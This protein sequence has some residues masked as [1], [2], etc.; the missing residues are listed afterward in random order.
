LIRKLRLVLPVIAL[1][2]IAVVF[3]WNARGPETLAPPVDDPAMPK[4][5]GKNELLN[6]RFENTDEQGQNYALSATRAVQDEHNDKIILLEAPRGDLKLQDGG[7]VSIQS[8]DGAFEQEEQKLLLRGDVRL[9]RDGG[10]ELATSELHIN[11]NSNEAVSETPVKA[12]GPEGTLEAAG[13]RGNSNTGSLL[14]TGPVKLVLNT[15]LF[16]KTGGGLF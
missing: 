16:E 12:Q 8:I 13:L 6:P 3:T 15:A 10:Y 11:M 4:L 2:M 5:A 1:A 9:F 14:F 7:W